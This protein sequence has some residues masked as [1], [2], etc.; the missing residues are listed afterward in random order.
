MLLQMARLHFFK[1]DYRSIIELLGW[2]KDFFFP[3]DTLVALNCP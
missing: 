3:E 1:T 2:Q